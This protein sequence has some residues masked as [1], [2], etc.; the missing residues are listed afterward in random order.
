M[1]GVNFA[2]IS[3][4]QKKLR[5]KDRRGAVLVLAAVMMVVILGLVALSVDLGVIALAKSELQ[6]STDA[7]ALAGAGVLVEGSDAANKQAFEMLV[8]NP[9]RN[10]DLADQDENWKDRL[11]ELMQEHDEEFDTE[12]GHWNPKTRTFEVSDELPSTIRVVSTRTN[13]P[14]FLSKTGENVAYATL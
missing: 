5:Q 7:A 4:T 10:F 9:V 11:E 13:I 3:G 2:N 8:H 12:V 1:L 14:L 6:R